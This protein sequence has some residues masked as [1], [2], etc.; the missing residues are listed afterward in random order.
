M[1]TTEFT[2]VEHLNELR[3]RLFVVVLA[4]AVAVIGSF[5][6]AKPLINY[7]QNSETAENITLNALQVMDPFL[8][9]LK[10]ALFLAITFTSPII[11]YQVWAFVSPGLQEKERR[12]TLGYIPFAFLLFIGGVSFSYFLLFPYLMDFMTGLAVELGITQIISIN[13]YFNFIFQ[14]TVPF[15]IIFQLPIVLLFLTRLGLVNPQMLT[16]NR[17]YAYFVLFI[18]AAFIT[19]PDIVSHLFTSV[20]LFVLYE[21][22]IAISRVGYRKY[23][24]AEAKRELEEQQRL[25]ELQ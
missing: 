5:F 20:P 1:N 11:L 14:I 13:D 25:Q 15:G 16:K 21:I 2:V 24:A 19:P 7:L 10:V 17:K 12:A 22:S 9:Y 4:L 8:I 6:L 3:K 23:L 18:I